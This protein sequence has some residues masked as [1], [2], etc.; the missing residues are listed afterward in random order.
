MQKEPKQAIIEQLRLYEHLPSD[1]EG[2]SYAQEYYLQEI[3]HKESIPR[4]ADIATL[5][6]LKVSA[7]PSYQTHAITIKDSAGISWMLFCLVVQDTLGNWHVEGWRGRGNYEGMSF[8][9]SRLPYIILHFGDTSGPFYAGC[10]VIDPSSVGVGKVRVLS[11]EKLIAEDIVQNGLA[12]FVS[13]QKS[14]PMP[15]EIELYNHVNELIR[16]FKRQP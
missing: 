6:F 13:D 7:I 9:P 10:F 5:Q 11:E 4:G 1:L 16:I 3:N 2:M 14:L 12:A 8:K 15:V